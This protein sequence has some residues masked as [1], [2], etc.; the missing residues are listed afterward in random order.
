MRTANT[1]MVW[2]TVDTS[3]TGWVA[4]GDISNATLYSQPLNVE[5]ADGYS[6]QFNVTGTPASSTLKLQGSNSDP[7]IESDASPGPLG[8]TM[9]WTDI[10]GASRV[11]AA[12]DT[13]MWNAGG[14]YY[15]WIRAVWTKTGSPVG[16]IVGRFQKK[17]SGGG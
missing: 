16:G 1:P 4:T 7:K 10:A 3:A 12:A 11:F 2:N 9:V 6:V 5:R 14:V 13:Q 17:G 15:R 8:S